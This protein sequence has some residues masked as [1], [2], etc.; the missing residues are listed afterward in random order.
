MNSILIT[1]SLLLRDLGFVTYGGSLFA[2][3]ALIALA[4]LGTIPYVRL[5]DAVR[6][7]RAWGPGLG[8]SMGAMVLGGLVHH[9]LT[10]GSFSWPLHAASTPAWAVFFCA[11]VSNLRLEVWTL[12]PVRKL[13]G[14]QGIT[15]QTAF[16]A[17][18]QWLVTHMGLQTVLVFASLTLFMLAEHP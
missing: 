2:F 8:L 5:E 10:S 3:T 9:Y 17:A 16:D 18:V 4:R 7:Y 15:D 1:L 11:W 12:E 14:E 6:V 13:D